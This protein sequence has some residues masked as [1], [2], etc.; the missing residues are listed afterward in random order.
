MKIQPKT[1][2]E[3]MNIVYDILIQGDTRYIDFKN[4][5]ILSQFILNQAVFLEEKD[6]SNK[7]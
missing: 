3:A 1:M 4:E 5:K 2:K 7:E 6:I